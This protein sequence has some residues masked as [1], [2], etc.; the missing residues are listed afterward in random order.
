MLGDGR[1]RVGDRPDHAASCCCIQPLM[2][3]QSMVGGAEALPARRH[4]GPHD[5]D[6]GV[7]PMFAL[8]W[9]LRRRPPEHG[10]PRARS[11][12]TVRAPGTA[13]PFI[14]VVDTTCSALLCSCWS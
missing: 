10:E 3:D 12:S 9:F 2:R 1:R 14:G 8:C 6:A 13:R 4:R 5:A 11:P 7:W